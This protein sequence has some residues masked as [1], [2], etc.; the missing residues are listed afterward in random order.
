M[1]VPLSSDDRG[2]T[3]QPL[4]DA[5][6]SQDATSLQQLQQMCGKELDKDQGNEAKG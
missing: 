2:G 3:A 1:N 4:L 6:V 5:W